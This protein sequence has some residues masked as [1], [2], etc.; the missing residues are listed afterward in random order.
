MHQS[1]RCDLE[2]RKPDVKKSPYC[3]VSF[4]ENSRTGEPNLQG[5]DTDQWSLE[6]GGRGRVTR[7]GHEELSAVLEMFSV[8]NLLID[9]LPVC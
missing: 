5:P 2:R 9:T 8:L 7:K 3:V 1:Q 4:M 6:A